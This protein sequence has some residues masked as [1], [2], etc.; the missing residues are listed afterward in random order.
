MSDKSIASIASLSG[1]KLNIK[2]DKL[3]FH[4]QL[5][6]SSTLGTEESGRCSEVQTRVDVWTVCQKKWLLLRGGQCC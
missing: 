5:N 2:V 6:L 1:F 3:I 4:V